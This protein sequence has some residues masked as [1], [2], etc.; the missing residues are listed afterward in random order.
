MFIQKNLSEAEYTFISRLNTLLKY[1][2][3]VGEVKTVKEAKEYVLSTYFDRLQKYDSGMG[4]YD[5]F[6]HQQHVLEIFTKK[7]LEEAIQE[8]QLMDTEEKETFIFEIEGY[9]M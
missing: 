4:E 8:V 9:H 1:S 7:N 6:E 5:A 3:A 2:I